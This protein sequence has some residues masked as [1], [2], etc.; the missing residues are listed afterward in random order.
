MMGSEILQNLF[1][2]RDA[3]SDMII[4]ANPRND[5]ER[6]L[7]QNLMKRR[8]R[9]TGAINTII[10]KTFNEATAGLA[11][12][13]SDLE[14][15]TEKL[16]KLSKTIDNVKAAIQIADQIIQVALSIL[17]LVATA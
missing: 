2:E 3:L 14:K 12:K 5:E 9:I 1:D 4:N 10:A 16:N 8:D 11:D 13:L 7:L 17:A 6:N 15:L